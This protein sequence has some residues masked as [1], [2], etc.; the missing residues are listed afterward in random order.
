MCCE[1]DSR[2]LWTIDRE[3]SPAV[4]DL[5]DGLVQSAFAVT[6]ALSRVAAEH[7]VS[8]TQFRV[9]AI[10]RDRRLR[11]TAL[12]DYLGLE[13][14]TLSGLVDRGQVRGLVIRVPREGDRRSFDVLLTP[15]GLALAE[16]GQAEVREA[17]TPL[18]DRLSVRDA[19][20]L[21]TLLA[22]MLG[23]TAP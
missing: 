9:L 21:Q 1:A 18:T 8:L 23:A 19:A 12:A 16:R 13:R 10:L 22:R 11:M 7:D 6:A 2:K 20:T 3:L 14:S 15:A 17:L 5:V 4:D